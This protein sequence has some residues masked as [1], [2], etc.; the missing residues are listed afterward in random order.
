MDESDFPIPEEYEIVVDLTKLAPVVER[1]RSKNHIK[2]KPE[3]LKWTPWAPADTS[4]DGTDLL[5]QIAAFQRAGQAEANQAK[6]K[7]QAMVTQQQPRFFLPAK[8][9]RKLMQDPPASYGAPLLSPNGVQIR[10]S[11]DIQQ[12]GLGQP[13][14]LINGPLAKSP[15]NGRST[16]YSSS[17]DP[18][19][20]SA[21]PMKRKTLSS[22]THSSVELP[23]KKPRWSPLKA[24]DI[25]PPD[26][27]QS[28]EEDGR[29][30]E[31]HVEES[32][33]GSHR[34]SIEPPSRPS[35]G[36]PGFRELVIPSSDDE[37]SSPQRRDVRR[38]MHA[39]RT[40]TP[41]IPE[42]PEEDADADGESDADSGMD[43]LMTAA[44]F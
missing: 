35:R 16:H 6:A 23:T 10:P 4:L 43:V 33:F 29:E 12:S 17:P 11:L 28:E 31:E 30:D 38:F 25:D 19:Q 13:A 26:I 40:T 1:A 34:S 5:Q 9:P 8:A 22:Q 37:T 18:L 32:D 36:S 42:S 2:L 15:R 44:S 41:N 39:D 21:P 20:L 3:L 24:K 27:P 7:Q 14:R